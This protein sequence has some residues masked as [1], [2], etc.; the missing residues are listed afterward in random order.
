MVKRAIN[1]CITMKVVS[2]HHRLI[3]EAFELFQSVDLLL[4]VTDVE[5]KT[6][7]VSCYETETDTTAEGFVGRCHEI[8]SY[9]LISINVATLGNYSWDFPFISSTPYVFVD[10][11]KGKSEQ[12]FHSPE[13]YKNIDEDLDITKEMVWRTLQLFLA[14]GSE[15]DDSF[16]KEYIKGLYNFH[17]NFLDIH[18]AN[19]AFSNFYRAFEYF[20]TRKI[21][22]VSKLT[23]EKQELRG[24]LLVFGFNEESVKDFDVL[25]KIRCNQAMHSQKGLE[26]IDIEATTRLK[27]FLDSMMHKFYEPIWK[28]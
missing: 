25:Y 17:H 5:Q 7:L 11:D 26:T 9:F 16:R 14:L 27:I 8:F 6:F 20:C 24:V 15:K 13:Q 12:L 1:P 18:F 4:K 22:N 28:K 21:L 10:K 3:P 23:N 19:E 2:H